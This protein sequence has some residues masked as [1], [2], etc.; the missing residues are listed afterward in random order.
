[1][2]VLHLI[3]PNDTAPG[4]AIRYGVTVSALK[5]ANGR[6]NVEVTAV[7]ALERNQPCVVLLVRAFS[8]L[9]CF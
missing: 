6:G 5:R 1:M 8:T 2:T 4:I 3:G 9:G 7:P